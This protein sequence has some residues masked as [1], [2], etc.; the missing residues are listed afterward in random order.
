MQAVNTFY[1]VALSD[2]T[3]IE[4]MSILNTKEEDFVATKDKI[5]QL[6]QT[7]LNYLREVG[8][9]QEAIQAEDKAFS[10][11]DTWMSEFYA[12]A[13]IAMEDEPQLFESLGILLRN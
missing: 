9:S 7:R 6:E 10:E 13:K 5:D 3:I 8:E 4:K 2:A 11:L 12:V 1:S